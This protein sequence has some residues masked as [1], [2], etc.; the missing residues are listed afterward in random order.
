MRRRVS[1]A[2]LSLVIFA[3][4]MRLFVLSH[5]GEVVAYSFPNGGIFS[6]PLMS[7]IPLELEDGP[8]LRFDPA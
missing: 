2:S 1:V 7:E 8:G 4:E 3:V 6:I 5:H